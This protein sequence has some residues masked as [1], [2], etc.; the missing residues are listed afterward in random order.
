[1]LLFSVFRTQIWNILIVVW[2]KRKK[3]ASNRTKTVFIPS[4]KYF[5]LNPLEDIIYICLRC[6]KGVPSTLIIF[7]GKKMAMTTMT[8][9]WVLVQN[10][11]PDSYYKQINCKNSQKNNFSIRSGY[12]IKKKFGSIKFFA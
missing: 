3:L 9:F 1:M 7:E 11:F 8:I 4:H 10:P 2:C 5:S 6:V 12:N